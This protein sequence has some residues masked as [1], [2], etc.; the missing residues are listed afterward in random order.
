MP[1]MTD[2]RRPAA[3]SQGPQPD[4]PRH[5]FFVGAAAWSH[6][7]DGP[8]MVALA[9]ATLLSRLPFR[10]RYL[11]GWDSRLFALGVDRFDIVAA[12]PH[13]PGFPVYI[14]LGRVGTWLLGDVNAAFVWIS[15]LSAASAV[16]LLYGFMREVGTRRS[17]LAASILLALSPVGFFQSTIAIS[18]PVELPATVGVGWLAWRI[19]F[20]ATLRRLVLLGVAYSL[21][22]GARQSLFFSLSPIV[23]WSV[24]TPPWRLDA[25]A[26][27]LLPVAASAATVT[28]LWF[29]PMIL[30]AGGW[31]RW[32]WVL[33]VHG[34]NWVFAYT[35]FNYGL[36]V[37]PVKLG[38]FL[39]YFRPERPLLWALLAS[40]LAATATALW[41]RLRG[42]APVF[43]AVPPRL[44]LFLVLWLLPGLLMNLAV[45]SLYFVEH[46]GYALFLLP[47]L[48]ALFAWSGESVLDRLTAQVPK[49]RGSGAAAWGVGLL[50]LVPAPFLGVHAHED[51]SSKVPP[52]DREGDH[53][54]RLPATFGA[55]DTAIVTWR[56]ISYVKWYFPDYLAWFW[57][58]LR[59]WSGH[60]WV[61]CSEVRYRQDDYPFYVGYGAHEPLPRHAIPD[62]VRRVVIFDPEMAEAPEAERWLDPSVP[63]HRTFLDDGFPIIFFEP[64]PAR[65]TL[66]SYFRPPAGFVG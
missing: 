10:S 16:A 20:R 34:D 44:P 51:W 45:Y 3:A 49:L 43:R 64:D 61:M 52:H 63:T 15:V 12:Q 47:G 18:Y 41:S 5:P 38:R 31:H 66:E 39:G 32:L 28:L 13:A 26:R 6:R 11:F 19:H 33:D 46:S 58:P 29:P 24:L 21:A 2:S 25:V 59:D 48:Y 60:A 40:L 17:A 54:S 37:L 27:R 14:G 55:N 53:W 57:M 30:A 23:A 22:I 42:H 65:P 7:V 9:L 35:L 62:W 36:E 56:S 8:V 4:R 50:L 1:E